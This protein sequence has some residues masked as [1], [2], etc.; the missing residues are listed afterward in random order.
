MDGAT[1]ALATRLSSLWPQL[2]STAPIPQAELLRLCDEACHAASALEE[3]VS[4]SADGAAAG[5]LAAVTAQALAAALGP[6]PGAA[7]TL[8]VSES[9][10]A[11]RL[12]LATQRAVVRAAASIGEKPGSTAAP[13]S[14]HGAL[15]DLLP[16]WRA[17]KVWIRATALL[18]V[19]CPE[20]DHGA[21]TMPESLRWKRR[22]PADLLPTQGKAGLA[23]ASANV[24]ASSALLLA[25]LLQLRGMATAGGARDLDAWAVCQELASRLADGQ[26]VE[27]S[28]TTAWLTALSSLVSLSGGRCGG[29][30]WRQ[31][32]A[33][34]LPAAAAA[35]RTESPQAAATG[36]EAPGPSG[37][38]EAAGAWEAAWQAA[39]GFALA[40]RTEPGWLDAVRGAQR[41]LLDAVDGE[42]G[43]LAGY[44]PA[45]LAAAVAG[46]AALR[47]AGALALAAAADG[48]EGGA[49]RDAELVLA[50]AA[51][52]S[53]ALA[54]GSPLA[55]PT[56]EA[57]AGGA[58]EATAVEGAWAAALELGAPGAPGGDAR[59][60]D[61]L[62][63]EAGAQ[64]GEVEEQQRE[65]LAVAE[66][67]CAALAAVGAALD[68]DGALTALEVGGAL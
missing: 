27:P 19:P 13:Q 47:A 20:A 63:P 26:N 31:L 55:V 23:A 11:L 65:A 24:Q 50:L 49:A 12:W 21:G 44:R 15:P 58:S 28:V 1:A 17:L 68:A 46:A 67:A 33:G 16:I 3:A 51:A 36:G 7:W 41:A 10:D 4:G 30:E 57:A 35:W 39:C 8:R 29:R 66:A 32:A 48:G 34:V 42:E 54:V 60:A 18:S 45:A 14:T 25:E 37:S 22:C 6:S 38:C 59:A 52:V 61:R 64:G 53:D 56:A 5:P 62:V 2:A 40:H 43:L 9:T